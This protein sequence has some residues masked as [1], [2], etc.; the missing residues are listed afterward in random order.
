ML[1]ISF[2]PPEENRAF[3]EE[4]GF[5]FRLVCDT[6]RSIGLAFGACERPDADF[7][8]RYTFVVGPD[9]TIE[10]S[11]ATEHPGSQAQELLATL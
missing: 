5:P 7:A 8:R 9:G 10:Q 1:G 11:I 4:F 2:D 3:A 6:D